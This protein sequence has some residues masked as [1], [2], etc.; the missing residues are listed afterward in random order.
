MAKKKKPEAEIVEKYVALQAQ[1]PCRKCKKTDWAL[2]PEFGISSGGQ[3][4]GVFVVLGA[5][6]EDV[7]T[8]TFV[9]KPCGN[10]FERPF[11]TREQLAKQEFPAVT[12]DAR[13][14]DA[15]DAKDA[16]NPDR[17]GH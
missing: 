6:D 8:G 11:Y 5:P 3:R 7:H 1:T 17:N 2:D 9:C 15:K 12:L 16:K 14:D 13:T 10:R 4:V